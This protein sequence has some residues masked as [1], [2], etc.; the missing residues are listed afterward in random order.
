MATLKQAVE[1]AQKIENAKSK[2]STLMAIASALARAGDI[3]QAVEVAQKIED[4]MNKAFALR[5]IA[6]GSG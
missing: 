6:S 3:K 2:A 1:V 4:A 5:D